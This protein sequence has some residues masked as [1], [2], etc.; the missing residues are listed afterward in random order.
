MGS[1]T[2]S[3]EC[4]NCKRNAMIDY[5]YKTGEEYVNCN[6]CGYFYS[7]SYKR[8]DEG[9]FVTEDGTEN[10]SF[11]NLIVEEKE[12]KNPYCAYMLKVK[13]SIGYQ[14]G[15]IETQ[16]D[17]EEFKKEVLEHDNIEMFATSRLVGETILV[18]AVMGEI[19]EW[20]LE[21]NQ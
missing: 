12:L 21:D 9:K 11:D 14:G 3:I 18:E 8:D 5:Y 4:P 6:H 2:D 7:N 17:L 19:P 13:G 1:V 16:E 20:M 15:A 10:Y